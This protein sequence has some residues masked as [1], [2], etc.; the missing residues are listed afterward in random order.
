[1]K[2]MKLERTI[3]PVTIYFCEG[4]TTEEIKAKMK[5]LGLTPHCDIEKRFAGKQ[6]GFTLSMTTRDDKFAV[7][8]W[9]GSM[10]KIPRDVSVLTH[11]CL[12]AVYFT[13]T[14]M[15]SPSMPCYNDQELGTYYLDY[16]VEK[17]LAYF[18]S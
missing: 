10:K 8:V 1:M 14:Y 13:F 18:W 11:E 12:H 4:G 17:S 9:F 2:W 15:S 5:R 6:L 7:L 3:Y 16:L